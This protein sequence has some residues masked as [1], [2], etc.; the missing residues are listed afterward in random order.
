MYLYIYVCVFVF[1]N[2][3]FCVIHLELWAHSSKRKRAAAWARAID[4]YLHL[5]I[6]CECAYEKWPK[7]QMFERNRRES[8]EIT[9]EI[10]TIR[11]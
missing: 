11:I 10:F 4:E 1:V 3:S 8:P 6:I 9:L 5:H 7:E 2:R